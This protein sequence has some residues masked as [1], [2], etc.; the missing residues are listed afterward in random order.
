MDRPVP[1][2][3]YSMDGLLGAQKN[4]CLV[5]GSKRDLNVPK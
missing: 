5:L 4:I 1:N 3:I 2:S